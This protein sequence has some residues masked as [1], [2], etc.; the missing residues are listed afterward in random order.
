MAQPTVG[1][2]I[3]VL[4]ILGSPRKREQSMKSKPISI[5]L[6]GQHM[7]LPP[8]SHPLWVPSLTFFSEGLPCGCVSQVTPLFPKAIWTVFHRSNRNPKAVNLDGLLKR[9][10]PRTCLLCLD[11]LISHFFVSLFA[12][13]CVLVQAWEVSFELVLGCY[14]TKHGICV[15]QHCLD[16]LK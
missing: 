7:L 4:V 5:L 11:C 8:G 16:D 15:W 10:Q 12:L 14:K 13:K 6:H 1:V 9:N 3:P 2:S